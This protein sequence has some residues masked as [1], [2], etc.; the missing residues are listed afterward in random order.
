MIVIKCKNGGVVSATN[1]NFID[2]E[3]KLEE[4]YYKAQGCTVETQ[5]SVIYDEC[6]CD[7]CKSLENNFDKLIEEIKAQ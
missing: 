1:P 7:H 4:A 6:G 5:K 3:W 2:A